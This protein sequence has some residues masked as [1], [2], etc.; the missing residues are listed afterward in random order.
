MRPSFA[1]VI[2]MFNEKSGAVKCI[3]EISKS[4]KQIDANSKI[5]AVDDGSSDGTPEILNGL[6]KKNQN[7]YVLLH[8]QNQGYGGA[9]KTGIKKAHELGLAYVLFMDSDLTNQPSDIIHFF[10][11]MELNADVIKATRYSDGGQVVGV[12]FKRRI[13]SR[14]GN[15]IARKL[16]RLPITDPTNGFRALRTNLA[17]SFDFKEKGFPIIME[18][19]YLLSAMKL[20][21]ENVPVT[22][23]NRSSEGRESSFSY[24][25]TQLL[26]YLKYPLMSYF[27]IRRI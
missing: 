1:V 6:L 2:P 22:L 20:I 8:Q 4:L 19:L 11:K 18:E 23:T 24:T 3:D 14:V 21:Y 10:K 26:N 9:L 17:N 7:L 16:L 12:P 5:I 27:R 13:I 25:P 15:V